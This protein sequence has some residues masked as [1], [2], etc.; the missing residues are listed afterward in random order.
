[1]SLLHVAKRL[2]DS[3]PKYQA[4]KTL[5]EAQIIFQKFVAKNNVILSKKISIENFRMNNFEEALQYCE[6]L[7]DEAYCTAMET[8]NKLTWVASEEGTN[9]IKYIRIIESCS[10]MAKD[11][12]S[13]SIVKSQ[14]PRSPE[15]THS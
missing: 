15:K 8:Y 2:I 5:E 9:Q 4:P 12:F 13:P 6:D 1:M 7:Y 3:Y 14:Y 10:R 11:I